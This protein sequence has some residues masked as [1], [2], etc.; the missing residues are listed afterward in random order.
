MARNPLLN[1]RLA[2]GRSTT[3]AVPRLDPQLTTDVRQV[4]SVAP[5]G[6]EAEASQFAVEGAV[7]EDTQ[8]VSS[9]IVNQNIAK[10]ETLQALDAEKALS[11]F[12]LDA[13]STI[14]RV[15]QETQD[16]TQVPKATM[17]AVDELTNRHINDSGLTAFQRQHINRKVNA[18][19][20]SIENQALTYQVALEDKEAEFAIGEIQKGDSLLVFNDPSLL[21]DMLKQAD[22]R[23]DTF[24]QTLTSLEQAETKVAYRNKLVN[25]AIRGEMAIDP[26]TTLKRL[27][28]GAYDSLGITAE[29]K[30]QLIGNARV[31]SKQATVERSL[32]SLQELGN[33]RD[34]INSEPHAVTD[35]DISD[36]RAKA[37]LSDAEVSS[38]FEKRAKAKREVEETQQDMLR[39]VGAIQDESITLSQ[40]KK[41]DVAAVDAYY[42]NNVLPSAEMLEPAA[43]N[44]L[45]S[46]Y[47]IRTGVMPTGLK[48]DVIGKIRSG[49][50]EQKLE[51]VD[52]LS[53]IETE[54]PLVVTGVNDKDKAYLDNVREKLRYSADPIKAIEELDRVRTG[55]D[56]AAIQAY[57]K[58]FEAMYDHAE[59]TED[60]IDEFDPFFGFEPELLGDELIMMQEEVK[61]RAKEYFIQ[62][63]D[64]DKAREQAIKSAKRTWSVS[65]IDG[66]N[67][68][69][70]FAPEAVLPTI[71]GN[72]DWVQRQI[73]EDL[74][75][76][77]D[78][79]EDGNFRIAPDLSTGRDLSAGKSPTYRVLKFNEETGAYDVIFDKDGDVIMY[80]PD[81]EKE[82]KKELGKQKQRRL[83]KLLD[84]GE[85]VS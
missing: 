33:F 29:Q 78:T 43:K 25:H 21:Q 1:L 30:Q 75:P 77:D 15:R 4:P 59:S 58:D 39:V 50:P 38:M 71:D 3:R 76:L 6:L 80:V 40:A 8:R 79:I 60:F 48:Q 37:N 70:K 69:M 34:R 82:R 73:L 56:P 44:T 65:D 53:R 57:E 83:R 84:T 62:N 52:I 51:A 74:K 12:Q 63:Q 19:R 41:E 5:V 32:E 72:H 22:E 26:A 47:V 24:G 27:E 49:S 35:E 23:I 36:M 45:L 42:D 7:A 54:S 14:A 2:H 9:D 46:N 11:N 10:L 55:R 31:K 28:A 66:S 16:A 81:I 64:M 61:S 67:R 13:Q 17:D 68:L 20:T 85:I 18:T